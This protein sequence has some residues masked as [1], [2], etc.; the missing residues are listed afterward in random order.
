M[1]DVVTDTEIAWLCWSRNSCA[2]C[3]FPTIQTS[4]V[5]WTTRL[6]TTRFLTHITSHHIT[7]HHIT[8]HPLQART[9]YQ[10]FVCK[11]GEVLALCGT[12][13]AEEVITSLSELMS[14]H[15][16]TLQGIS[17]HLDQ[18]TRC[19]YVRMHA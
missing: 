9:E 10:D 12:L 16:T 2:N 4:F 15:S 7:S 13:F 14:A 3:S 1:I 8:H 19:V 5:N 18:V 11:C 6:S 17:Q